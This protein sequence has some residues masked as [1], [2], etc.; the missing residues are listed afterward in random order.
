MH[1]IKRGTNPFP[2]DGKPLVKIVRQQQKRSVEN[3]EKLDEREIGKLVLPG[4]TYKYKRALQSKGTRGWGK[5]YLGE[6]EGP[7]NL[8]KLLVLF[9]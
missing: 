2:A 4:I 3:T 7:I 1:V 6:A 8:C 5:P 9:H